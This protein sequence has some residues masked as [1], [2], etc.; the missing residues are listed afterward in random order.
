MSI[1]QARLRVLGGIML[2]SLLVLT[3]RLWVLQLAQWASY[4]QAATGNRTSVKYTPAP[5]G[6]IR[7][8][9]GVVLAGNR[10]VWNVS[11][12]SA[13]FPDD[14][15][16][17]EKALGRMASIL[18]APLPAL[19]EDVHKAL[20]SQVTEA[21]PLLAF[22]QDVPLKTV[23]QVEEQAL[24]LP[25]IV[26]T[27][28]FM[29]SYPH[30]SLAAHVLGYARAITDDQYETI[31]RLDY[32][33]PGRADAPLD[34]NAVTEDPIYPPDAIYGKAGLENQY[35]I[36]L[37]KSPPL[38]ILTGRRGRTVYEVDATGSRVRLIE[39]RPPA[40]GATVYLTLDARVQQATEAALKAAMQGQ[41]NRT[42]AAVV[43]D[44]RSGDI[45]ALASFPG[46]DPNV[47]AGRLSPELYQQMVSDP[48][49]VF[50][51][52]AI[53]GEYPPA[54]TF[55]MISTTAALETGR[56]SLGKRYFCSGAINE[57]HQRFG[58]WKKGGHGSLNL[59]EAIAQSCDVYFYELVRD[60]GLT[61]EDLKHYAALYGFGERTGLDLP[62]ERP[63]LVPDRDWKKT[64]KERWWRTGDTLNMVI[65]QG[66]TTVT[67]LQLAMATAA[68]ANGGELLKPRL[69][70]K[71]VWPEHLQL[72][73][74]VA[75]RVVRWRLGVKPE[76]L[77]IVREG[78]RLAITAPHGTGRGLVTLPISVAGKTGSAEHI[79]GR[80]AHAWFTCLAPYEHPRYVITV[81]VSEGGHG[82]TTAVPAA[83]SI[84]AALFGFSSPTLPET[85]PLSAD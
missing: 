35:E 26:I 6:M 37:H 8:T 54:S 9:N 19:R 53:A 17:Q 20:Q 84:L 63:G 60:A 12:A 45:I 33:S 79:P 78:M 30:A 62:E 18:Q 31:K 32:P 25:G 4:A 43:V 2:V 39:Q 36:D 58:C 75:E 22:G 85:P 11:V 14:Q 56:A 42:G 55:K 67:P 61:P 82:A 28:S 1:P 13:R 23:A 71:I 69:V 41:R 64:Q 80:P 81:F 52:K 16:A 76:T 57:G 3:G 83:R 10:P 40:V 38:P 59:R 21:A 5:R 72:A 70:R 51:N 68:V 66:A 15:A 73:P 49:D 46:F 50:L 27:Q 48:R 24:E 7:D 44:V 65:G 47:M 77:E 74:T 34:V 29:R